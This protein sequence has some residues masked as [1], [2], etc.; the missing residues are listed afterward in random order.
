MQILAI[1]CTYYQ[2][3]EHTMEILIFL[4]IDSMSFP[5]FEAG[6]S[7][8]AHSTRLIAHP[9]T[10]DPPPP[11]PPP[12]KFFKFPKI[13]KRRSLRQVA[14]AGLGALVALVALVA[15]VGTPESAAPAG[16]VAPAGKYGSCLSTSGYIF[17][18]AG[19][20]GGQASPPAGCAGARADANSHLGDR[21]RSAPLTQASL[22]RHCLSVFR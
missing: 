19:C 5:C 13:Q 3:H 6:L 15:Q 8:P 12:V 16:L 17:P 22:R 9:S 14:P 1:T 2:S 11:P 10:Q 18:L 20:S 21:K 4:S 7:Q